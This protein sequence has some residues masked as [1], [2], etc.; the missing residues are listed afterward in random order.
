MSTGDRL[1]ALLL[2]VRPLGRYDVASL[3]T[4]CALQHGYQELLG[5]IGPVT[6]QD[7]ESLRERHMLCGDQRDVLAARDCLAQL[8]GL[9]A[10]DS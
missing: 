10:V 2:A 1:E 8:L 3:H 6:R 4:S 5:D 9:R 7:L